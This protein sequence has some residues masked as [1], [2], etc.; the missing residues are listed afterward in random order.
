[1]IG[2]HNDP[3]DLLTATHVA[4]LSPEANLQT[5]AKKNCSKFA[6]LLCEWITLHVTCHSLPASLI[7]E[8][9]GI[10]AAFMHLDCVFR[11]Q[12]APLQLS[13]HK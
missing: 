8:L 5:N 7:I 1:M 4:L 2:P 12:P 6:A 13:L 10:E 11:S 3:V 9:R